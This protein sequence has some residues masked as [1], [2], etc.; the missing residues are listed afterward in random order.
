M[1][2]NDY[3]NLQNNGLN[4]GGLGGGTGMPPVEPVVG[5]PVQQPAMGQPMQSVQP[6]Q[7]MMEQPMQ[8]LQPA[9]PEKPKTNFVMIGIIAGVGLLL[10][11]VGI[12]LAL[13]LGGNKSKPATPMAEPEQEPVA[14][15]T[16]TPELAES[17]CK[18]HGG[19]LT[20]F[21]GEEA[22]N[23]GDY[24]NYTSVYV[25]QYHKEQS[26]S[27]YYSTISSGDFYYQI[28]FIEDDMLDEFWNKSRA[29]LGENDVRK[30]LENSDDLIAVYDA[31][32]MAN[33]DGSNVAGHAYTIL[34]KN[35]AAAVMTYG[36][37]GSLAR[38]I[39]K[40]LG[41]P[42]I[43]DNGD[44]SSDDSSDQTDG[45]GDNSANAKK[46][47]AQRSDDYSMVIT[48]V[49]SFMASNNGKIKN[50]IKFGII[51]I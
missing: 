11:V 14:E 34:Y 40:E 9:Q 42:E 10:A 38:D 1:E 22:S 2:P 36:E 37:D 47:D 5:Q 8:P 33:L 7:P 49:N 50:L 26:S 44:E 18:K 17:V 12:V 23:F 13:N 21:E 4:G 39:L 29:G 48:S 16:P 30:I 3:N 43:S 45:Q 51:S 35:A 24:T 27:E 28:G 32:T 20:V 15:T 6:V 46:R 31:S 19:G 25:C 41:F